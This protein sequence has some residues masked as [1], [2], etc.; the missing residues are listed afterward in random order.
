MEFLMTKQT[1]LIL[2]P[3]I[4]FSLLLALSSCSKDNNQAENQNKD[5]LNMS[6]S[7][8]AVKTNPTIRIISLTTISADI[9]HVLSPESLVGVPGSSLIKKNKG[10]DGI[11]I[12]TQGRNPPNNEL[13]VSLKPDLVIGADGFHDQTLEHLKKLGITTLSTKIENW[14]DFT[15]FSNKLAKITNTSTDLISP[16][17]KACFETTN[18]KKMSTILL[19]SRKPLLTPNQNSWAGNMLKRFGFRNKTAEFTGSSRFKGYINLSP[20]KLVIVNPES[21]IVVDTDDKLLDHLKSENYWKNLAAVK[22]N[23]IYSFNYYGLV[24][25][26]SL[27]SINNTCKKL[28]EMKK[29]SKA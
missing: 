27:S 6:N 22:S 13:V 3:I 17:I 10:F 15:E 18:R 20:E 8:A 26:G 5:K 23:N 2:K 12:V 21:L 16:R 14:I 4:G 28:N 24:N 19:V 9:V 7:S 11:T 25:P 1:K 29:M